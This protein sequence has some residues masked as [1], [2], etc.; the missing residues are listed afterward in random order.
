M[1]DD[2]R[3]IVQRMIDAGESEENI[4]TVIRHFQSQPPAQGGSDSWARRCAAAALP[5]RSTGSTPA[6]GFTPVFLGSNPEWFYHFYF[7]RLG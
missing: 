4:A 7:K 6:F 2:Q 3:A 5:L 1:A